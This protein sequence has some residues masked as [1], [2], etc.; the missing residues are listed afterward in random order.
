MGITLRPK[1]KCRYDEAADG[2]GGGERPHHEAVDPPRQFL[3]A[4]INGLKAPIHLLQ[5]ALDQFALVLELFLNA[6]PCARA[7]RSRRPPVAFP[8]TV[9]RATPQDAP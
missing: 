2:Q 6:A 3:E 9:R 1:L 4:P 5:D 7:V 8:G